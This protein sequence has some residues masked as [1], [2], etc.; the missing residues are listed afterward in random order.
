[1]GADGHAVVRTESDQGS[2]I[3]SSMSNA[4]CFVVLPMDGGRVEPGES[5]DVQVFHG[6]M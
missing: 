4:N 2:G 1:M 6:I 3:L 5:V